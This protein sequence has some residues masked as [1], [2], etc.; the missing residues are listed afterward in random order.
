MLEKIGLP[1][2]PSMR[3]ANWVIDASHCQGCSSQFTF[4][5]RKHH[6]RRCG[7]I[8]CN[9]CTQQRMVLRGQGD[10]PVRICDPCK[11]LEE[12]ARFELR[13]G[14]K[15]RAAKGSSKHISNTEDELLG[16]ILPTDGKHST[17]F[18]K[19]APLSDLSETGSSASHANSSV[20][21]DS[22]NSVDGHNITLIGNS[23]P[24]DLRQQAMEEKKKY[25]ILKSEG[26][27]EEALKAFKHGKELERQA[28]AL[29]IT[30][31]KNRKMIG[32]VSNISN[33][34]S[35]DR[36]DGHEAFDSDKKLTSLKD[37][38]VK[39]DL[40]SE[41][42]QLG[43][44][45]AELHD[46]GKK[47]AKLS[48]EGELSNLLGETSQKPEIGR[49]KGGIDKTQVVALKRKALLLKREGKLAEAKEE[50]KQAKILEK[51]LEEQEF[52][53]DSSDSEDELYTLIHNMDDDNQ[54]DLML[55]NNLDAE[56]NF[57]YLLGSTDD[58]P[59]DDNLEV[60]DTDMNDPELSA[61]L[62]SFGWT[63]E[64]EEHES[65]PV[66]QEELQ[67]KVLSLKK[68]ALSQKREGKLPEAMA[69]LKKAKLLEQDLGI[70][71]S[72]ANMPELGF[73]QKTG[74]Y[75]TSAPKSK[76]VIQ[77]EL[78]ALKRKALTLRREGRVEEADEELKKGKILEQR[79]EELENALKMP[80]TTTSASKRLEPTHAQ[81]NDP[82]ALDL[83]VDGVETDVTDQ[84]MHDPSMLSA[85]KSLGWNEDESDSLSTTNNV[86]N[87]SN[88]H[89][90]PESVP[91]VMPRKSM[92][93][94][95]EIQRELLA[96]KR[97]ALS[98]R[99]QGKTEEA[100]EELVKAKDLENLLA[101]LEESQS[102]VPL[103]QQEKH[104]NLNA[105]DNLSRKADVERHISTHI[106]TNKIGNTSKP[107]MTLSN[108]EFEV[109]KT[110]ISVSSE[111]GLIIGGSFIQNASISEGVLHK[112]ENS[113]NV[114]NKTNGFKEDIL[115]HK[116]NALAL[117]RE[118]KLIEAKEEL[119]KAKLLEKTFQEGQ[120]SSIDDKTAL[121]S[122]SESTSFMQ[123]ESSRAHVQKP[124]SSR[125]R[126]KLQQESLAHKRNALKLRREGKIQEADS[127]FEK[128]K[129]LENQLEELGAQGPSN[130][131]SSGFQDTGVVEDLLD[132]QLMS[133]LKSI[134]WDDKDLLTKSP[135]K[136]EPKSAIEKVSSTQSR[137]DRAHLEE[138][139]KATKIRALNLKRAGKQDEALEAL[140]AAKKLEKALDSST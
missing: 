45:D 99:R 102:S 120:E 41:L 113:N 66:S 95:G 119:R 32:K 58:L 51:R 25:R 139:I 24:E 86:S 57:D 118:G 46:G 48:L 92:R 94:K 29:E 59:I 106:E 65:V 70:I 131:S 76:M 23:S 124:K 13:Y 96:I 126:F 39:D 133:A 16:D 22:S 104:A 103:I 122:T 27:D 7:G 60:T 18:A 21:S 56:P 130:S 6:C 97:K 108:S 115:A 128:A 62:K 50:L 109:P 55:K 20:V 90:A 107:T 125:D 83:V 88:C 89:S 73:K 75:Q 47:T 11:K 63:E 91:S 71:H 4:F 74:D 61:A 69:L 33:R 80:E 129:E 12:A 136:P 81:Y 8:F 49:K 31:R 110:D 132:P 52:L 112:H 40:F 121:V 116:R 68:E 82:G 101:D 53:G 111:P 79:L 72:E 34:V 140:R 36:I 134:G 5:N 44:S 100:E 17:P 1:A 10:S 30:I 135:E 42:R 98:L 93:N 14:N 54:D 2:K 117:K 77:K 138:Q 67:A 3:G 84:D 35:T 15:N 19:A 26:K 127:E 43:W 85:L 9:S 28:G 114:S 87:P 78:L 38:E 137:I 37:K 123:E 105:E 64:D